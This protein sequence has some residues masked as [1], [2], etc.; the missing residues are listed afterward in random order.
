MNIENLEKLIRVLEH[1]VTK[2]FNMDIILNRLDADSQDYYCEDTIYNAN[3]NLAGCAM[4]N[5]VASDPKFDESMIGD[6]VRE[7]DYIAIARADFGIESEAAKWLFDPDNYPI[8][9][10]DITPGMV[11]ARIR[12]LIDEPTRVQAFIETA[13]NDR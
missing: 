5:W 8:D 2:Y 1:P 3:C 13:P 9:P 11:I 12:L 7:I 4:G 10:L 6:W